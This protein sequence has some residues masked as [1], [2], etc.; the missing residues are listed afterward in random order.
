[1]FVFA[2]VQIDQSL[3]ANEAHYNYQYWIIKTLK[4]VPG[5]FNLKGYFQEKAISQGIKMAEEKLPDMEVGF[6]KFIA[7]RKLE[8]DEKS[9]MI[10]IYPSKDKGIILA[11]V[12]CDSTGAPTRFFFKIT[13]REALEE[14]KKADLS[15]L[16]EASASIFS[17]LIAPNSEV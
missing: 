15:N 13:L 9:A 11:L 12:A 14:L 6:A 8:G 5:M 7:E 2:S 3:G 4:K 17:K 1:M 10:C 16:E